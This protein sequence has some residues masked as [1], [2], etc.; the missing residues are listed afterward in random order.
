MKTTHEKIIEATQKGDFTLQELKE[1]FT[2]GIFEPVKIEE[3]ASC[4]KYGCPACGNKYSLY[5]MEF[6]SVHLDIMKKIFKFC[7]ENRVH[8]FHKKEIPGLSHT[9]YGN[10]CFLQ[11]FG[12]LYFLKDTKGKRV[13]GGYWGMP[14]SR[15]YK[16]LKGEATCSKYFVR[17]TATGE[18]IPAEEK[19]FVSQIKK[20]SN[21]LDPETMQPLFLSHEINEREKEE[22]RKQIEAQKENF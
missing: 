12:F 5:K 11:R 20:F 9:E 8:E 18:N 4:T 1:Y 21:I 7:I 22:A 3:N 13:K 16:F 15:V 2:S 6:S 14:V 17:N 10:F 19:I